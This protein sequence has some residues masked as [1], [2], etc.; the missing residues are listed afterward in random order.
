[1]GTHIFRIFIIFAI[2]LNFAMTPAYAGNGSDSVVIGRLTGTLHKPPHRLIGNSP[3]VGGARGSVEIKGFRLKGTDG[4]TFAIRPLTDGYFRQTLPPGEY[5]LTRQRRDRSSYKE[6]S[7]IVILTFTVP[8]GSIVNLGTL[9]IVLQGKPEQVR[10]R[11]SR[12][13]KGVY[14]YRYRYSRAGGEAAQLAPL[15]WFREKDTAKSLAYQDRV[16]TLDSEPTRTM[17]SSRFTLRESVFRYLLNNK[18]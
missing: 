9:D 1:M 10:Y 7:V 14:T 6:D 17:D 8:D 4:R 5:S 12:Q 3:T 15:A 16:I 2:V 18:D 11:P 13:P